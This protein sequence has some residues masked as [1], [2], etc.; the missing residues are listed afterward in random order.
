MYISFSISIAKIVLLLVVG[1]VDRLSGHFCEHLTDMY[2]ATNACNIKWCL[3]VLII[4]ME[5]L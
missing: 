5:D 1:N 3:R 4:I 2:V